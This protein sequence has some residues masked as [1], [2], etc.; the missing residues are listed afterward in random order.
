[1][2]NGGSRK[3][4][5]ESTYCEQD[6]PFDPVENGLGNV[7]RLWRG[8]PKVCEMGDFRI[9][10]L[11]SSEALGSDGCSLYRNEV[12][13]NAECAKG[14]LQALSIHDR[15]G[16]RVAAL[17]LRFS[18]KRWRVDELVGPYEEDISVAT[19]TW[20]DENGKNNELDEPTDLHF[21]VQE[22]AR[23]LNRENENAGQ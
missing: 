4:L 15:K 9:V 10:A 16:N 22:V 8:N 7:V 1:M 12:N 21:L 23:I 2:V 13:Y 3:M 19:L 6:R 14:L 5:D 11:N 18:V 20:I 17:G